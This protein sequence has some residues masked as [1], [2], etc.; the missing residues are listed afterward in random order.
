M[1]SKATAAGEKWQLE[2]WADDNKH[3][4]LQHN[5]DG[6]REFILVDRTDAAKSQNLNK[7]LSA[8][9]SKLTLIDKKY[10]QYYLYDAKTAALRKP[11]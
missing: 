2:E 8:D 9:P 3:V 10:D 1:L 7:V 11:A 5:Y 4:V 6:K